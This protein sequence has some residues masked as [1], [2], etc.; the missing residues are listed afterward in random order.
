MRCKICENVVKHANI[1]TRTRRTCGNCLRST[2]KLM[3]DLD[4]SFTQ[5]LSKS[6]GIIK[7]VRDKVDKATLVCLY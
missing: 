6:T 5:K 3:S 4:I 2:K 1:P 7:K